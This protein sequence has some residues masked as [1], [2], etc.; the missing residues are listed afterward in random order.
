M[1]PPTDSSW[2]RR[3]RALLVRVAKREHVPKLLASKVV[4]MARLLQE[5]GIKDDPDAAV[6][7]LPDS[8][9]F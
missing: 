8:A 5:I 7:L 1:Y 9:S 4:F 6:S 2:D 3:A